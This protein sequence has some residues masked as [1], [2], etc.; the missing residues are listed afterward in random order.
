MIHT[1]STQANMANCMNTHHS[2]PKRHRSWDPLAFARTDLAKQACKDAIASQFTARK[3]RLSE[4]GK[5]ARIGRHERISVEAL[6]CD[7]IAHELTDAHRL[8]LSISL[9]A[10]SLSNT[11]S[12]FEARNRGVP[13]RL[14][15]LSDTGWL[16]VSWGRSYGKSR[17]TT[18]SAGPKLIQEIKRQQI[19]LADIGRRTPPVPLIE[20]K[21]TIEKDENGK[22]SRQYLKVETSEETVALSSQLKTLNDYFSEANL[23]ERASG[24]HSLDIMRR[25][26][27]RVFLEGSLRCGGR[28]SGPAFWLSTGKAHRR[29]ALLIDGEPIAELDL[30]SATASLAY[31][32][33][34]YS[35]PRDPYLPPE[36]PDV[37]R[38]LMKIAFMKFMWDAPK[39]GAKLPKAVADH[40]EGDAKL[41]RVLSAFRQHNQEIAHY[42]FVDPP[43]GPSL[44][45]DESEIIIDATLRCFQNDLTALPLHDALLVPVSRISEAREHFSSAFEDRM[46]VPPVIVQD[47]PVEET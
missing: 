2:A 28:L 5:A 22:K 18:F 30:K 34:G 41:K 44:M 47:W 16:K 35:L 7:A 3:Q 29:E 4:H 15:D 36:F 24:W 39:R 42:L 32:R 31:A 40:I 21:G 23:S 46:G 13:D 14:S 33:E 10:A 45:Y 1:L 25:M 26:V 11:L 19:T 20:L 38:D 43:M 6:I 27:K 37:P 8:G 12:G 9:T 17:K